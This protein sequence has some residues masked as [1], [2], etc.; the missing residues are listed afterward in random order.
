MVAR[1]L[2]AAPELADAIVKRLKGA[3]H[4]CS[5][6]SS[7]SREGGYARQVPPGN[8]EQVEER[9]ASG[10]VPLGDEVAARVWSE[11]WP[12]GRRE[13]REFFCFGMDVL[14]R[15][16]PLC[17]KLDANANANANAFLSVRGSGS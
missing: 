13:Q 4:S 10:N 6:N 8:E 3:E 15:V 11:V 12:L 5:S 1:T 17:S 9:H 7:S 16:S 2:A 14:L